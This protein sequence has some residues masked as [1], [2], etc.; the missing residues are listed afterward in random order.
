VSGKVLNDIRLRWEKGE[1]QVV[2]TLQ[3]IAGVAEAGQCIAQPRLRPTTRAY[4]P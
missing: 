4:Q 1:P 3:A 2:D